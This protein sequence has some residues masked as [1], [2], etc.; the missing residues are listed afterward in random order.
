MVN[1]AARLHAVDPERYFRPPYVGHR[2]WL[3]VRIDTDPDWDEVAE[4]VRDAYCQVALSKT[5]THNSG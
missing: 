5:G 2:G 1:T 3:G 4:V